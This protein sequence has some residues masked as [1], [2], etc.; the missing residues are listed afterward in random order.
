MLPESV[1]GFRP[2]E[3]DW[4]VNGALSVAV[5]VVMLKGVSADVKVSTCSVGL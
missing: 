3:S 2:F 1:S 4:S 5:L